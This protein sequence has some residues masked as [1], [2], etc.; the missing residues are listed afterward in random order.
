VSVSSDIEDELRRLL[1]ARAD[2]IPAELTGPGRGSQAARRR[3]RARRYAP[4]AAATGVVLV[5]SAGL[6]VVEVNGQ[7]S[8]P[9]AVPAISTVSSSTAAPT[10]GAG[11]WIQP[12]AVV[13]SQCHPDHDVARTGTAA[14]RCASGG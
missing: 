13:R 10:T 14:P 1:A 3:L 7:L 6:F 9:P 2:R 5:A 12:G 4:F 11:Q 8:R